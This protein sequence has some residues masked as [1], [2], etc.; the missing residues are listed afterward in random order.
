MRLHLIPN[1]HID[2][3]WLWDKYEG[4]DEVLNT[5]RSAC[6]RLDEY[7]ALTFAASSLQF[8]EWV[9]HYDLELFQRIKALV[10]AGR[11]EV[12][13]GWWVEADT[14]LPGEASF[15]KHA[16]LSQA[17][18]REHFGREINVAYLPDTF[19]HPATLPKILSKSGF[20]YLLFA[21]PNEAEKPDLPANLFYWEYAGYR[22]LAYRLKHH[23][24]QYGSPGPARVN[25]RHLY[26]LLNDEEYR[27]NPV[28]CY[29]FGVGDHGGGPSIAEIEFYNRFI[30]NQPEKDAA[31][32]T[33]LRFFE[34]A[35]QGAAIPVYRGD[36]HMHAAGCYSVM[37]D[38]KQAVRGCEHG[39]QVAARAL[40]M[41]KESDARLRAVWKTTLFNQFHDILPG[42]CSPDAADRARAEL[43]GVESTWRDTAYTALQ[44]VS[45]TRP[46]WAA[47]GEFRI[48]NTL[49]FEVTVPLQIESFAYYKPNAAF[50]DEEGNEIL[51]QEVLPSVR[52]MN[53]RWEFVDSLPAQGFKAYAF[54]NATPVDRPDHETIH[55]QAGDA[56][57]TAAVRVSD[58]GTIS[59]RPQSDEPLAVLEQPMRFLVMD[60]RSDTWGHGVKTFDAVVGAFEL[61]ASSVLSGLVTGKLYQRWRY[62]SSTLEVTTSLYPRLPGVYLDVTVTWG[63]KRK[64]LKMEIHPAGAD[65]PVVTMQGAGGA[66]ERE[67]DGRELPLHHWLWL[68]G[69][70]G[71]LAVV[72]DG[73]FAC[74]VMSG[75]L[76]L[77][78][79]RSSLYGYHDPTRLSPDDP[80]RHTDQGIRRVRLC[81]LP[82]Q[83]LG[84]RQLERFAAAFVEPYL[85]IREGRQ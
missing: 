24:T 74:D 66:I 60:D 72:Q 68:P 84:A 15:F 8:Y 49:P 41:N 78:L 64:L 54:D 76:R 81:L 42:S 38:V 40:A 2:P 39:L 4:I 25:P 47:E 70:S 55:F 73:A 43:G 3:V 12:V 36:L 61:E 85:I 83:N 32:S 13:G 62:G 22:V 27:K 77:T 58:G 6:A 14:N 26:S 57:A 46:A 10:A 34:E 30:Q 82:R 11:W 44:S 50:R 53:R 45:G 19:G 59:L 18:T 16:E 9:H 31:Y 69:H 56:I 80:Q 52:C 67:A 48:F 1:S 63:E 71:G 23:Y 51:I 35:A 5:F 29:L 17:F 37:G 75:R 65:L 7:P 20:K 28:N 33:C 21:R 79:V